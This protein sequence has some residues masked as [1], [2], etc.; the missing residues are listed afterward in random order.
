MSAKPNSSPASHSENDLPAPPHTA[1]FF[2]EIPPSHNLFACVAP[3]PGG[4]GETVVVDL[5]SLLTEAHEEEELE[6]WLRPGGYRYRTSK[7]LGGTIHPLT[8][9]SF[10]GPQGLPF[11]RYREEYST[12]APGESDP[13]HDRALG[14]LRVLCGDTRHQ[15]RIRL[16]RDEV[17]LFYNGAPHGRAPLVH[18]QGAGKENNQPPRKLL[19]CRVMPRAAAWASHFREGKH[20]SAT[21][22]PSEEE[23]ARWAT[24]GIADL[25]VLFPFLMNP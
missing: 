12:L 16:Q 21:L 19:R 14:R 22:R 25:E 23:E 20:A 15:L 5:G 7:R 2:G 17:L 13:G 18:P 6:L 3:H 9:L 1:G 24:L 10:P 11:L 4:G 8:L